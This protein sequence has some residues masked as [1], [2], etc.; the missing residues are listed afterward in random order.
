MSDELESERKQP[1]TQRIHIE[2]EVARFTPFYNTSSR[3]GAQLKCS[4]RD[5]TVRFVHI[6][7]LRV[8]GKCRYTVIQRH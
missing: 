4:T 6:I 1:P 5:Q 3:R 2:G 7:S 8:E